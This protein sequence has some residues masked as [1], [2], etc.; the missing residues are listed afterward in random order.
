MALGC[1]LICLSYGLSASG[2]SDQRGVESMT[3]V[4]AWI[5]GGSGGMYCLVYAAGDAEEEDAGCADGEGE[6]CVAVALECWQ[7]VICLVYVHGLDNKEVV[8]E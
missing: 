7:R 3:A 5:S 4:R 8:V 1:M 2:L 6:T